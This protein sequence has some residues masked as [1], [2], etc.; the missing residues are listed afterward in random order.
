MER[1]SFCDS[2]VVGVDTS[3]TELRL[4]LERVAVISGDCLVREECG[5]LL[6]EGLNDF[7]ADDVPGAPRLELEYGVVLDW[8]LEHG[9]GHF[10]IEWNGYRPNRTQ[11]AELTFRFCSW[12]WQPHPCG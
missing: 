10:L 4:T 5:V 11:M 3:G 6:L 12:S 7:R 2:F 9:E 1:H 8:K